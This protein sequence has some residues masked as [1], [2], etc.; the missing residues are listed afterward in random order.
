[1]AEE[2]RSVPVPAG[3]AVAESATEEQETGETEAEVP[4]PP[5]AAEAGPESS[6]GRILREAIQKVMEQ[7]SHHEREAKKHLRQADQLRKD[8]RESFSFLQDQKTKDKPAAAPAVKKMLTP[9]AKEGTVD[10]ASG[11]RPRRGK[12]RRKSR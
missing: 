2:D 12:T 11:Q 4:A 10:L 1:M 5:A 3:P 9:E 7:I 8:L 6:T